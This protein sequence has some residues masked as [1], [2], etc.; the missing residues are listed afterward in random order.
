MLNESNTASVTSF[1]ELPADATN[2]E[3]LAWVDRFRRILDRWELLPDCH[4]CGI[5]EE[6][7][8]MSRKDL[9]ELEQSIRRNMMTP[10]S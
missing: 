3:A 4:R 7:K 9:D 2:G 6:I 1:Q 8:S 5:T 10:A